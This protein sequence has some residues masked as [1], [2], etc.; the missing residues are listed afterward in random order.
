MIFGRTIDRNPEHQRDEPDRPGK[1]KSPLPPKVQ[2]NPGHGQR[3]DDRTDITPGVEDSRGQGALA[4][5]EPLGNGFDCGGKI[6][7][8]TEAERYA[9]HTETKSGTCNRMAHRGQTPENKSRRIT[10]LR[11]QPIHQ[12]AGQYQSESICG[13]ESGDDISIVRLA[14]ANDALQVF[15][16]D[17]DYLP[18]DI[19]DRGRK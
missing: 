15:G 10:D 7:R 16:E 2:R 6:A 13:I 11:A 12:A 18:I 1:N 14:P 5:W 9:R 19:V 17:T 8:F 3:S 4:F